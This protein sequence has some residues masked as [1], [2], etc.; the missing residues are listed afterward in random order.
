MNMSM[1]RGKA[2]RE[3]R[4]RYVVDDK[5][6]KASVIISVRDYQRRLEDLHD[7]AIVAERRGEPAISL[8]EVQRRLQADGVGSRLVR[9]VSF[10]GIVL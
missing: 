7:L 10:G 9:P 5:G 1:T 2:V 6:K 8:E 4:E 3:V